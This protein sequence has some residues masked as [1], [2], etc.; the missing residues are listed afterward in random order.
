MV[1]AARQLKVCPLVLG[2]SRFKPFTQ[3]RV[4]GDKRQF[5]TS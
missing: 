5:A 4:G 2:E 1:V 3:I